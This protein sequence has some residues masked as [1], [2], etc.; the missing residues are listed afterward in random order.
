MKQFLKEH[1]TQIILMI[2]IILQ[3]I[4]IFQIEAAL[5]RIGTALNIFV[6]IFEKFGISIDFLDKMLIFIK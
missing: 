1:F 6:E 4:H 5:R 2:T 3:Q